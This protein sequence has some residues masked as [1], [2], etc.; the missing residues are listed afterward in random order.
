LSLLDEELVVS[1]DTPHKQL[2]CTAQVHVRD[3]ALML[4]EILYFYRPQGRALSV[5]VL[6]EVL[7]RYDEWVG[8]HHKSIDPAVLAAAAALQPTATSGSASANASDGYFVQQRFVRSL[9][10]GSLAQDLQQYI[11]RDSSEWSYI[12]PEGRESPCWSDI[13]RLLDA[14]VVQS[15]PKSP[16]DVPNKSSPVGL[17]SIKSEKSLVLRRVNSSKSPKLS[18][19]ARA[20]QKRLRMESVRIAHSTVPFHIF[21]RFVYVVLKEL[22]QASVSI[23]GENLQSASLEGSILSAGLESARIDAALCK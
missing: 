4:E 3:L 5:H 12:A 9:R 19:V 14:K 1:S 10:L 18:V 15:T 17:K 11:L 13:R 8:L 21:A 16:R 22:A 6:K 20:E 23:I 7:R 2:R